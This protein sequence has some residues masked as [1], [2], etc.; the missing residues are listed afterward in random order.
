MIQRKNLLLVED[1]EIILS[2]LCELL[3]S[4]DEFYLSKAMTCRE[5]DLILQD[6]HFDLIILNPGLLKGWVKNYL[7][8]I[9]LSGF[10]GP[11]IFTGEV[12]DISA[13][14]IKNIEPFLV[15]IQRPFKIVSLL[16]CIRHL[17]S[18]YEFSSEL[19]IHLGDNQFYPGS[20]FIILENGQ[21][22]GL[23]D[24]ETNILK[25]LY[26]SKDHLV[27]K[28]VLLNEVWSHTTNLTTHTLETYI[29]RLRKKIGTNLNNQNIIITKKGGYQ[30]LV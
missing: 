9:S 5:V 6:E 21:K 7:D 16:E 15:C 19:I 23:T 22:V 30:L 28:E 26:R 20:K 11:I 18:K 3:V 25:F 1:D 27:S 13:V 10:S 8:I 24:K 17:L 12:N 2:V 4:S 29:Y 14:E